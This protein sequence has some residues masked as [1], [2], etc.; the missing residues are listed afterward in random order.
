MVMGEEAPLDILQRFALQLI[1]YVDRR[2]EEQ[3]D[4]LAAQ[5]CDLYQGFLCA[6]PLA[7]RALATL[8]EGEEA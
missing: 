3:R 6:G 1:D 7:E 2:D 4:L 5:G 8:V